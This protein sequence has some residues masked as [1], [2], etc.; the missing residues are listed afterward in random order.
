VRRQLR[1]LV[2]AYLTVGLADALY[3]WPILNPTLSTSDL[4]TSSVVLVFLWPVELAT[5]L[6]P[7]LCAHWHGPCL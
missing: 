3:G 1:I 7:G 2:A 6:A 4:L 5:I